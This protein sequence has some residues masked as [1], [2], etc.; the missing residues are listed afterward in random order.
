LFDACEGR[1]DL[2]C[3]RVAQLGECFSGAADDGI[4]ARIATGNERSGSGIVCGK[5]AGDELMKQDTDRKNVGAVVYCLRSIDYL[6]CGISWGA[7]NLSAFLMSGSD[8]MGEAEVADLWLVVMIEQDI[9][10]LD[11]AV[12]DAVFVCVGEALADAGD[13]PDHFVWL[14]CMAVGAM[15]K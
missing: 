7:V 4:E 9:R 1:D 10:R 12:D 14:D 15:E 13:E 8:R 6:G 3:V 11:V 5:L 2:A